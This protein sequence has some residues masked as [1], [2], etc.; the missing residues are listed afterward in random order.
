MA[1]GTLASMI[2][3]LRAESLE[4]LAFGTGAIKSD[5]DNK[6]RGSSDF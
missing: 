1:K 3:E 4:S 6:E 2:S 5:I